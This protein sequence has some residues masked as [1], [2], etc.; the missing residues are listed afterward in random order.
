M[1]DNPLRTQ[2]LISILRERPGIAPADFSQ[3]LDWQ[4]EPPTREEIAQAEF[5]LGLQKPNPSKVYRPTSDAT[6]HW[7]C[8]GID[9]VLGPFSSSELK[10]M[11]EGGT[12][13]PNARVRLGDN[14]AWVFADTVKGLTFGPGSPASESG[15]ESN[16]PDPTTD[17][18]RRYPMLHYYLAISTRI[19]EIGSGVGVVALVLVFIVGIVG[20]SQVKEGGGYLLAMVLLIAVVGA[21]LLAVG[22]VAGMASIEFIRVVIDVEA[23]TRQVAGRLKTASDSKG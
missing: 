4:W 9:K 1:T 16:A 13:R 8:R 3:L 7:Y 5:A 20:A 17:S 21:V 18:N 12:L 23:N 22:F 15:Q 2:T 14:S 10:S 11:A 6:Q 19:L